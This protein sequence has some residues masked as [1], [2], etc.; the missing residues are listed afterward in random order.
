MQLIDD[1]ID[2]SVYMRETDASANVR[3]ASFYTQSLKDRLRAKRDQRLVYL[4]WNK[5]R[6]NFDFRVGEVTVWAGVNGHGKS[7]ITRQVAISLM[8]QGQRVCV[9]NFEA[10]PLVTMQHMARMFIGMNPL[11]PEFQS[12]EGMAQ[13]DQLYDSFSDFSDTRL[14][15]YDQAGTTETRKVIGMV[16][17]CAKEL[18]INHIF[19]DNLAKCVADE[20]DYNGQKAFVEEMC[21]IAKDH[22]CHIHVVHHLKKPPK[23]TDK[24]DKSDV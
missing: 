13:I 11:A 4:P 23:E 2:F 15:F 14:W 12:D 6:A 1:S 17:Y 21:A 19:V 18:K 22:Q 7:A 16:R 8:S 10:K 24:P 9:A 3:P 20:D 5:V